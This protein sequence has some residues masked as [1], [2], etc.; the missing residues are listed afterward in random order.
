MTQWI[1]ENPILAAFLG[2]MFTYALTALG[3]ALV[4]P[5]KRF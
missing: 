1:F 3:S 5:L 2:T 4:F